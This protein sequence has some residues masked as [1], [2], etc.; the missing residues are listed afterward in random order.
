MN[1]HLTRAR[2][3]CRQYADILTAVV[4]TAIIVA[5]IVAYLAT[6]T[7]PEQ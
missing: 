6:G 4:I 1:P 3:W 7:D 2:E 5:V